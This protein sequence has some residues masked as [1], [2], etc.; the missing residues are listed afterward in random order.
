MSTQAF[1]PMTDM[2]TQMEQMTKAYQAVLP[3]EMAGAVNLMAHPMAGAAAAGAIGMGVAG[4]VAG[5]WLG[6]F[7]GMAQATHRM[8]AD[9]AHDLDVAAAPA[10]PRPRKSRPTLVA[11][12]DGAEAARAAL[13]TAVADGEKVARETARAANKVAE[14][15]LED[16]AKLTGTVTRAVPSKSAAARPAGIAQPA[17]PDDL[18]A[19]TGIGPKLEKVLNGFGIWTYGQIA[20]LAE[21]EIAWLDEEL[22]FAGRIV[23]DDWIGQ[24]RRLAGGEEGER[25]A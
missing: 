11:S 10:A 8:W 24:A 19:I 18:K 22:G 12:N 6:T 1:R 14:A 25:Q 13:R 7:A 2:T 23:R 20:A 4:H 9:A 21:A 5:F 15:V 16:A 3:R 17:T